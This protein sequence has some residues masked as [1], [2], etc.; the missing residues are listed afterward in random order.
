MKKSNVLMSLEMKNRSQHI[1]D[2]LKKIR[3]KPHRRASANAKDGPTQVAK[4]LKKKG[5]DVTIHHVGMVK[6]QMRKKSIQNRSIS[7]KQS[8]V[9]IP[10]LLIAKKLINICNNDLDLAK[11]NLEAVS[12]L[13]S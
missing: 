7:N 8:K 1:R 11:Y 5:I 12:K 6:L 2:Y 10:N 9:K 4:A 3:C 13:L